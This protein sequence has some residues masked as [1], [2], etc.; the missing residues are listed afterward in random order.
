M[1]QQYSVE[2]YDDLFVIDSSAYEDSIE[3]RIERLRDK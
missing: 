1:M 2:D 3:E